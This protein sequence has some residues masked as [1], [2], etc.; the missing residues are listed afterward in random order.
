MSRDP[1]NDDMPSAARTE[2]PLMDTSVLRGALVFHFRFKSIYDPM[3][4]DQLQADM[5][6]LVQ[7]RPSPAYVLDMSRVE[8]ISSGF[9]GLLISA[10]TTLTQMGSKI[11][12]CGL[13]PGI[14]RVIKTTHLDRVLDIRP[15]VD[16][17]VSDLPS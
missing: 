15:S 9:L 2:G 5:E 6:R 4:I 14:A 11:R 17:A 10:S 8:F 3:E 13:A 7:E 12:V 16:D 1:S